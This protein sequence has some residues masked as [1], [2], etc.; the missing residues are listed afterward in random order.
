[1]VVLRIR[2]VRAMM[3][4]RDGKGQWQ[5][6]I[7]DRKIRV[8]DHANGIEGRREGGSPPLSP[9][10][11]G[12]LCLIFFAVSQ[13][14]RDALFGNLFQSISFLLI[15]ALAFGGSVLGFSALA[16]LRQPKSFAGLAVSPARLLMLNITTACA[17]L[18]FFFGLRY[19][20]PAVVATLYN[21]MGPLTVLL[22]A[23]CIQSTQTVRPSVLEWMC[24]F[25]A[26]CSLAALTAVVLTDHSGLHEPERWLQITALVIVAIG[27]ATIT[28]SHMIARWFSDRGAGSDAI[29]GTRFLVAVCAAVVLNALLEG[30]TPSPS[31]T[32]L[33][34]IA[35]G[36][37]V[38]IASPSFMLQLGIARTSPLG[39]NVIR[40]LGPVF[41]F[42][43]QQFDGRL[44][45]SVATLVCVI[46]YAIFAIG[47]GVIRTS[48]EIR[49]GGHQGAFGK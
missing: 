33:P 49:N 1:M 8:A 16:L 38:L 6:A 41:V 11:I 20:E 12:L 27:G 39:V 19:L 40:A 2:D 23:V 43:I 5:R 15:A 21:G 25:G 28:V 47:A 17:W 10:T 13:G 36:A 29:T 22:V 34:G 24:Y 26:T 32:D 35:I 9:R 45:L 30:Q 46:C 3:P 18:S 37:F 44:T 48:S 7:L 14:I 4:L 31:L 42:A